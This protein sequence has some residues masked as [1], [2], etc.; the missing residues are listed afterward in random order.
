MNEQVKKVCV[1]GIS[2]NEGTFPWSAATIYQGM[3]IRHFK[4]T[5]IFQQI[6]KG[7]NKLKNNNEG[8]SRIFLEANYSK[9][10]FCTLVR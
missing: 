7:M 2:N 8:T 10:I 3:S 1:E 5:N 9:L 4:Y 6:V